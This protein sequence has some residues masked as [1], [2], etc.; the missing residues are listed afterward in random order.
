MSTSL[1]KLFSRNLAVYNGSA[2]LGYSLLV[3]Q[4]VIYL[5][6]DS[7]VSIKDEHPHMVYI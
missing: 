1:F 6:D 4:N 7:I 2:Q 5:S 3:N